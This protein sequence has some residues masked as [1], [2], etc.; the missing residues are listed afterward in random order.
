MFDLVLTWQLHRSHSRWSLSQ[1]GPEA[2][3]SDAKDNASP[4]GTGMHT[5]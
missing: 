3:F 5:L 1:Q 4:K 2:L